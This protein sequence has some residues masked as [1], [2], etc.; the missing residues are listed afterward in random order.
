[1]TL[2]YESDTLQATS[3]RHTPNDEYGKFLITHIELDADS[4]PTKPRT[5]MKSSLRVRLLKN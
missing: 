3:K 1:M 5:K 4:I 2:I